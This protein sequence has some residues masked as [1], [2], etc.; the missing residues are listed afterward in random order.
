MVILLPNGVVQA[1]TV[2]GS[3]LYADEVVEG[4]LIDG[5]I[6][7]DLKPENILTGADGHIVLSNSR[8]IKRVY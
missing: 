2:P 5:V 4:L 6:Y 3:M 8:V 1:K 7:S